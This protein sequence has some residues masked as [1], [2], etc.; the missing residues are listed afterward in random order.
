MTPLPPLSN[1]TLVGHQGAEQSL[2]QS[3]TRGRV[4]HGWLFT[5]PPGIGKAT[6]AHRFARFL[7]ANP[8]TPETGLFAEPPPAT[9]ALDPEH[10]VF[11]RVAA[12]GHADLMVLEREIDPK[13]KRE[14]GVITVDQ[15]REIGQFLHLTSAE[16]GRRV[17]IIDP[18][19]DLN[20]S[21]ANSLLKVLEEPPKDTVLILIS[22]MPG[23]LLPTIRSRCRRLALSPLSQDE[24]SRWFATLDETPDTYPLIAALAEGSP[25]RALALIEEGALELYRDMVKL[26][27]S[28][29]QAALYE[30]GDRLGRAT[31][32]DSFRRFA[33]LYPSLLAR[34][35]RSAGAGEGMAEIVGGEGAL[36]TKLI[37]RVGLDRLIEVWEKTRQLLAQAIHLNLDRKQTVL[38]VL[39]ALT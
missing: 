26:L 23:G 35:A 6:L 7:L 8:I 17:V 29:D 18:I 3:W 2:I 33:E 27:A 20:S 36:A 38:E 28:G 11:R 9:L 21:G 1:P 12:G 14:R 34:I 10:P 25:G 31:N 39:S 22:H 32:A 24:F 30:F 4:P 5:G 15:I 19:D 13:T 16:G 37:S